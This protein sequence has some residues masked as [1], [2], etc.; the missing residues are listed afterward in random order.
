[1]DTPNSTLISSIELGRDWRGPGDS[2]GLLTASV[3]VTGELQD[4]CPPA[5]HRFRAPRSV[6]APAQRSELRAHSRWASHFPEVVMDA[7]T[8]QIKRA[9]LEIAIKAARITQEQA[10]EAGKADIAMDARDRIDL[11][12]EQWLQAEP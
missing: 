4:G 9:V 8:S 3:V 5:N 6:A 7:P 1:M 11:L 2:K 12:L 10:I